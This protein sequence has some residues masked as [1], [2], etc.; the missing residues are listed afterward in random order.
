MGFGEGLEGL[1]QAGRPMMALYVGGMGARGKNFYN[2]LFAAFGYEQ[3][4]KEI[5]DLYLSGKKKEAAAAIPQ[6]FLDDCSLI[7]PVGFVKERLAQ[8]REAGVNCLNIS[9]VGNSTEERV[10]TLDQLQEVLA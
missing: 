5:Q 10:K 4:A 3:E 6:S 1:R 9:L 2:D 8:Y 7:G